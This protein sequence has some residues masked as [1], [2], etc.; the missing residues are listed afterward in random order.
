MEFFVKSGSSEK[1]K[2]GCLILGVFDSRKLSPQAQAVDD[3][4]DG[5]LS[6]I[7]RR[8]DLEGK[9]GQT[10]L[11]HSVPNTNCD[12]IL[13]VGCGKEREFNVSNYQK[14]S[15][16]IIKILDETG[17]TDALNTLTML[18]VKGQD[19]YWKIRFSVEAANESLY[20][21]DQL[22]SKK[23][24]I[25]RPLKKVTFLIDSRA[26]LPQSEL[27][28]NQAEAIS[29][30]QNFTR[31]LANLPGNICHPT[32]LADQALALAEQYDSLQVNILDEAELKEMGAGAFV[33]VSQGSEQP[34]KMI[35]ME[36]M[37][38]DK[39]DKPLVFVGK[40]ITFDTGGISLKPGAGMDEMKYDMGGAASVYG[41]IKAVAEMNLPINV[42][43]FI[44]A[45]ENMPASNASRPGD[46][47]TSLSGQTVEILNTDAEGRLVLCDA[48][49]YIEKYDPEIVIDIAT[50]T[51]AVI[52]ALGHEASGLMS[53]NSPLAHEIE[54]A[55]DMAHDRVWRLPIWDEY[56]TQL[57][58][59]FAD[60]SNLG[61]RPAGSITAAC[62]LAK[63]TKKYRWAHLDIAG[64]AWRSGARKGS[65][66]RP[67]PLLTQIV[68]NRANKA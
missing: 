44:A 36:Y 13:L 66:G 68:L 23:S 58:S 3:V 22:K 11:L 5:H 27:A 64:T 14:I 40:G 43:G 56:H 37:A 60:F 50:L 33:S 47:V 8:G 39:D 31:D 10:L 67:V 24:E 46:I 30:G 49:T 4:S 15:K 29:K 63:F 28:I 52:I 54:N 18:N 16:K 62:F 7:L 2:T 38:G 34:G 42:V 48:L 57:K 32:Y 1:Q 17:T 20:R 35:A 61:G 25:R 59:N 9:L 55:S 12:R 19:L 21:F 65:T 51:G 53:N 6:A 45:A 41:M 26:D